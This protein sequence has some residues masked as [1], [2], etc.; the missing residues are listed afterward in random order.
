MKYFMMAAFLIACGD[1]DTGEEAVE[2]Q[3]SAVEAE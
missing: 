1:K 3:D 2:E